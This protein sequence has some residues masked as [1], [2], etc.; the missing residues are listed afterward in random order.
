M[1]KNDICLWGASKQNS[2]FSENVPTKNA[3]MT[4][5]SR[6][7]PV[8]SVAL[9]R[10]N[11]PDSLDFKGKIVAKFFIWSHFPSI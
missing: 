9:K 6:I 10:W 2:L 5:M 8:L 3:P 4:P 1:T 7:S 11:F